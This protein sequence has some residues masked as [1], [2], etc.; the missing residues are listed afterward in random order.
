[1]LQLHTSNSDISD[2][3]LLDLSRREMNKLV[4]GRSE[5]DDSRKRLT[6]TLKR[7]QPSITASSEQREATEHKKIAALKSIDRIKVSV[8]HREKFERLLELWE[9][10]PK[11]IT[12]VNGNGVCFN[13]EFAIGSGSYGTEVYVCLHGI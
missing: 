4:K 7:R 6:L 2:Q 3:E 1:M 5:G 13:E 11:L 12:I 9:N 10:N 8:K